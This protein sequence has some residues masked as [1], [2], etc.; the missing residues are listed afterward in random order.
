MTITMG[1]S[2]ST[3]KRDPGLKPLTGEALS[4]LQS[5]TDLPSDTMLTVM[6]TIRKRMGRRA[7]EPNAN[8]HI[9]DS[10]KIVEDFFL[11]K[12]VLMEVK[13][14]VDVE[15]RATKK[16]ETVMVEKD[17]VYC[18][19]LKGYVDF[20]ISEREMDPATAAV[21]IGIDS[22]RGSLKFVASIYDPS[23]E[24]PS[25]EGYEDDDE[26]DKDSQCP[27]KSTNERH[28]NSGQ[29]N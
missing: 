10:G 12:K 13:R 18:H 23:T 19:D 20:V 29:D 8:Q 24:D 25:T 4:E 26:D 3:S 16:V 17:V 21:R 22:G 7:I 28:L 11:V 14:S 6:S 9:V 5:F 1:T 27:R 2:D 15:G